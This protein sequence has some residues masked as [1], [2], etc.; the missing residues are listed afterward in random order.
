MRFY[1]LFEGDLSTIKAVNNSFEKIGDFKCLSIVENCDFKLHRILKFPPD[2]V[3]INLDSFS[4]DCYGIIEKVNKALGFPPVYIGITSSARKGFQALKNGF[5]DVIENKDT[6]TILETIVQNV[7]RL[8]PKRLFCIRYYNDFQY[9]ILR[10]LV[11]LKAD[12]YNTEFFM[13]DGSSFVN[14]ETLKNCHLQLPINFQRIHNSFVINSHY[15]RR[16]HTGKGVLYVRNFTPP[17]PLSKSFIGN[18]NEVKRLLMD[19]CNS[20]I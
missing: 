3:F 5:T 4:K 11:Y 20:T 14:F 18:I 1:L 9:L 15:V 13:K 2:L 8:Q 12:G 7:A 16:I 10:D 17:I 19:A 6:K